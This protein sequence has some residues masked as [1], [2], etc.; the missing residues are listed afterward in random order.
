MPLMTWQLWLAKDLV[1][2]YHL[3]WQKQQTLLTPERVAQSLFS[4]L[5]EIGSPAQPPKTRGKSPGWEKGKTRSKRKTYPTVKKRHS[6]PKK[7]ATKAS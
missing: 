6:T 4:L 3:P 7:S 1:A 2:D 5:I